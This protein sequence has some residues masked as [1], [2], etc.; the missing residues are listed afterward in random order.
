MHLPQDDT[1]TI[2]W[3]EKIL[4]TIIIIIFFNFILFLN[5]TW[6]AHWTSIII[7]LFKSEKL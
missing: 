3:H 2:P 1:D 6:I 4:I 5:F 7:I